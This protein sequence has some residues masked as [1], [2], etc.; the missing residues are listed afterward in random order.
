MAINHG[1]VEG[2]VTVP[3]GGWD[4]ACTDES[5]GP[6][7]VTLA[8]GDY[9]LSGTSGLVAT[10]ET[11]INAAMTQAWTVAI[12]AGED[13]TGKV[14]IG[15][16][17]DPAFSAISWTDTDL[18][19]LLGFTGNVSSDVSYVGTNHAR[20][21]WLPDAPINSPYGANDPLEESDYRSVSSPAGHVSVV[22]SQRRSVQAYSWDMCSGAKTRIAQETT[23]NESFQK[24]W[25]DVILGEAS[26]SSLPGGPLRVY[27]D[28]DVDATYETYKVDGDLLREFR[29]QQVEQGWTGLYMVA[30][31]RLVVVP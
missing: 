1:K 31:P 23:T 9:Y 25:R 16:G 22:G 6:T 18:R 28:A 24:F 14:T 10:L 7:T 15:V 5:G 21:L 26:W 19:D 11:A 4:V 12:G 3:T 2:R 27:P 17:G 8:A 20:S 13:G 29:P 30:M